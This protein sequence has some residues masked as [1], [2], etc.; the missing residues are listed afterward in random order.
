MLSR[1]LDECSLLNENQLN[2]Y[3]EAYNVMTNKANFTALI[4]LRV[5]DVFPYYI[6]T[7]KA[8]FTNPDNLVNVYFV[9]LS[10]NGY[11][12]VTHLEDILLD[13]YRNNNISDDIIKN[14]T[15]LN[16]TILLNHPLIPKSFD[17]KEYGNPNIIYQSY[18]MENNIEAHVF[19]IPAEP[20]FLF[21]NIFEQY[22]INID[23]L[24]S[25]KEGLGAWN[26]K[27][28]LFNYLENPKYKYICPKY[29][30][31]E[32]EEYSDSYGELV[33]RKYIEDFICEIYKL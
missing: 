13:L 32:Y 18:I 23:L 12:G 8:N 9:S 27:N 6:L 24:A 14:N 4:P 1:F 15:K 30:L 33:Y 20:V 22:H 7:N 19:Y 17:L 2:D 28:P 10:E 26:N 3:N 16:K 21:K 29:F 11:M 31:S 25:Y 5:I